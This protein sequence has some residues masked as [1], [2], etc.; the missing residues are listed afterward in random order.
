MKLLIKH[1]LFFILLILLILITG[2]TSISITLNVFRLNNSENQFQLLKLKLN[3]LLSSQIEISKENVEVSTKNIEAIYELRN[4]WIHSFGVFAPSSTPVECYL[5]LGKEIESIRN[6]AQQANIIIGTKCYLGFLKYLDTEKLPSSESIKELDQQ[7][8]MIKTIS[9]VL[10]EALPKEILFIKRETVNGE[11]NID[12]DILTTTPYNR[13][14]IHDIFYSNA[15]N[16]SFI[17]TTN[18][19]RSFINKIES[20]ENPSFIRNVEISRYQSNEPTISLNEEY[21]VFSVIIEVLNLK[22]PLT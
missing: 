14:N 21:A 15:F 12:D 5:N 16:V 20:L 11:S 13:L 18:T 8:Q 22:E 10:T 1:K 4:K 6:K 7:S 9:N 17:G 2:A 19:L 3:S